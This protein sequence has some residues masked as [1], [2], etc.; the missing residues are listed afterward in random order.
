LSQ[1]Y[2]YLP[3]DPVAILPLLV[4]HLPARLLPRLIRTY[5]LELNVARVEGRLEGE[6]PQERFRYFLQQ[7]CKP[8][9]IFP[10]LEEYSVLARRLVETLERWITCEL[11][12][13]ERLCADW[14]EICATF[15]QA[16]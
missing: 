13:L 3:F 2:P 15:P 10:L 9:G 7:L 4:K 6:T 1:K 16:R 11:E 8:E 5:V 12:L 14:E